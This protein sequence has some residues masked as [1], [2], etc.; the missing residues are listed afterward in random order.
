MNV[1]L[2]GAGNVATHLGLALQKVNISICGVYSRKKS[3]AT[4]LSAQLSCF[5]TTHLDALPQA[6]IYFLAISDDAIIDIARQLTRLF[7]TATLVHTAGSVPLKALSNIHHPAGV[8]YPLQTFS[9]ERMIDFSE[10]P[11]F[12][13]A[14]DNPT[15]EKLLDI[16]HRLSKNVAILPSDKRQLLHL[17]AVF[18]CNF[19]NHCYALAEDALA[20]SGVHIDALLPLIQE[21]ARKVHEL[22]PC[23]A[24][25]GPA[26]RWDKSVMAKHE[27]LLKT[28]P[29][30]QEIYRMMS[31]SIHQTALRHAKNPKQRND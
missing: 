20:N 12:I 4:T 13:E 26:V 24:Q 16:A 5:G 15:E 11:L 7:P 3:S 28:S 22:S 1:A 25:T 29:A 17:A 18:A 21:T 8:L 19:V 6:D 27:D 2:I 9:K 30:I 10:V 31:H 14:T 23:T